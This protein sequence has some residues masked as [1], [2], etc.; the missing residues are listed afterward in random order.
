[1]K[2]SRYQIRFEFLEDQMVNAGE[3]LDF[4]TDFFEEP[5][6]IKKIRDSVLIYS[7]RYDWLIEIFNALKIIQSEVNAVTR[8][9]MDLLYAECKSFDETAKVLGVSEQRVLRQHELLVDEVAE[10]LGLGEDKKTK[11]K[12]PK[13]SIPVKVKRSVFERDGGR[14][15]SCRT[16]DNLHYHHVKRFSEGGQHSVANL[17]LLCNICH[18]EE[19][20]GEKAYDLLKQPTMR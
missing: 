4:I 10:L 2:K 9:M 18:A 8:D 12:G 20:R 3:E 13:R 19:H 11:K 6:D 7:K 17:R 16:E 1:M 5:K 14:C 15:T